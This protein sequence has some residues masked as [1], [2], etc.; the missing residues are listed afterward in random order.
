MVNQSV[1]D[2]AKKY[3]KQVTPDLDLKKAYLFGSRRIYSPG[4]GNYLKRG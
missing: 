2:T 1:I 3:I 4:R